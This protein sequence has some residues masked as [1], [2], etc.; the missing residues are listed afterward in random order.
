MASSQAVIGPVEQ[1]HM[2]LKY[3]AALAILIVACY[4]ITSFASKPSRQTL[5]DGQVR[6]SGLVIPLDDNGMYI[7][8]PQGQFEVRWTKETQVAL[9]VNTRQFKNIKDGSLNYRVRASK[10]VIEFALP[11]GPITGIK[12][13]RNAAH[14]LQIADEEKWIAEFGLILRFGEALPH[15]LSSKEDP[16]FVGSY[17]FRDG[18]NRLTIDDASYEVSLKKGGQTQALLFGVVGVEAV[19]PFVNQAT[20]VGKLDGDVIVASEIHI[21]PIGDSAASDDPKLPR[22]LFIGDSISGNYDKGLRAALA[23]KAN[24]HHPPTNCG[25]VGKGR[26]QI[27][28]WLGAYKQP[29]R[30]WDI[31]SFNFGHWDASNTKAAYQEDLEAVIGE[32]EKTKAKLIWVTTCPVPSGFLPAGDLD[33]NGKAPA[34]TSGVMNKYLN[35]WALEV[36]KR[37]P[38]ITVCDQ[39]QFVKNHKGDIYKEW[40]SGKNVHFGGESADAL[41]QFLAAHLEQRLNEDDTIAEQAETQEFVIPAVAQAGQNGY[42]R[43]ELIYS[44]DDKPTPQCHASTVAETPSGLVAAWF[45]GE[46]EK[47]SDVGIW[48]SRQEDGRW[49]KPLE[50]ADGSEGEDQD[51]PCWNPVLFHPKDGPLML[52]YKVGPNPSRWWGMLLTS[53]DNGK[54]WS[55]RRKL[56]KNDK[57]GHLLGPVKNKPIQLADGTILC[58]SSTEHKGWRVHFELTK[59]LGKTWQVIG[60]IND[61]KEFG[62]I[63]PSIL[64]YPDG[65]MQVMCRSQQS[66]ITQ[67]WSNDGGKTWSQMKATELPNP[68][69]G[70]D[71]V[72]LE[73]GRQ[74]LV[75]NHTTRAKGFPSGRNMLNVAISKDGLNWKPV[76]TLERDKGEFSYP[77]VIE[78]SDG[79]IHI[80]YTYQRRSVKHVELEPSEFK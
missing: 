64:T 12:P 60:P 57:I 32:L 51:Y 15:Q 16:R 52:F 26:S 56:G 11:D 39:W 73:D 78:T 63:Q 80:T 29:G 68:N 79:K 8:N 2:K 71:A 40:W 34:R 18:P 27:V 53:H 23:G 46:H 42:I 24:L 76:L 67:S 72:T 37:H 58:P 61:G 69:A 36:V 22:Y 55:N 35:P 77:A 41:G 44:L 62:A 43:G 31:I 19:K 50:V 65:K 75:Y 59:D 25:P 6:D 48:V 45:G 3:I 4:T 28:N 13:V 38:Q 17:Q 10:E 30:H 74:L 54:N 7:R 66:V 9:N 33:S 21:E 70:T 5:K 20:V 1:N 47:N 14:E 49:S